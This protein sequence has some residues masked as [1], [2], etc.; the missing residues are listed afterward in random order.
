MQYDQ[1]RAIRRSVGAV[2]I[3]STGIKPWGDVVVLARAA[4]GWQRVDLQNGSVTFCRRTRRGSVRELFVIAVNHD[5]RGA[6]SGSYTVRGRTTCPSR[7]AVT[8]VGAAA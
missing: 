6:H 4:T 8:L 1:V 2:T 3:R 5:R 7:R